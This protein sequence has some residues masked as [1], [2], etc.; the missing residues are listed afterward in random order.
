MKDERIIE[1]FWERN[2]DALKQTQARYGGF[3][4]YVASGFLT[5]REDIEECI[6]DVLLA[7]WKSIPPER[8]ESL[9]AYIAETVRNIARYRSRA[10]NAWKRGRNTE[11]V[12]DEF[13]TDLSDGSTLADD[14]ESHRAGE[15]V[16]AFLEKTGKNERRVFVM[17][18]YLNFS[19]EQI[20]YQTGYSHS[21]I[22]SLLS[23]QREALRLE[24]Q[25]EGIIV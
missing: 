9:S 19:I 25:K 4:H 16:N 5:A 8:P 15:I 22:K 24:L 17:R 11:T 13:L 7:L 6:N 14:Y 1:L 3:C 10:N 12:N 21:K 18:Y 20:S 2:E 23:R